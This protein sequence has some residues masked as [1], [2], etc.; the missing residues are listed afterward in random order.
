MWQFANLKPTCWRHTC[1]VLSAD[2]APQALNII[3]HIPP[4]VARSRHSVPPLSS[5]KHKLRWSG[6]MLAFINVRGARS[7]PA[8]EFS[9][10]SPFFVHAYSNAFFANHERARGVE[11]WENFQ[12]WQGLVLQT[13]RSTLACNAWLS[14]TLKVCVRSTDYWK[15]A[16]TFRLHL[17]KTYSMYHCRRGKGESTLDTSVAKRFQPL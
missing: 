9:P 13:R 3:I 2:S 15:R 6:Y 14:V 5:Q 11:F 1:I 10:P 17:S 8:I 16:H 7:H 4:A 12:M